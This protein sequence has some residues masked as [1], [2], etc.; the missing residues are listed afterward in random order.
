MD[1]N[2]VAAFVKR[3]GRARVVGADARDDLEVGL[4]EVGKELGEVV[5]DLRRDWVRL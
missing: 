2:L 5:V 4:V 3:V 1:L